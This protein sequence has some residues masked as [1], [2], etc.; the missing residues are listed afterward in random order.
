MIQS[1]I[2]DT[3]LIF[4]HGTY[5]DIST[6]CYIMSLSFI[7]LFAQSLIKSG[8]FNN[9]NLF[10]TCF[11][12][13]IVALIT[14]SELP[15]YKEW[16][17]KL[18][19]KAI[20]YLSQPSEVFS[21]TKTSVVVWVILGTIIQS[22]LFIV[23]YLKLIYE[24]NIPTKRNFIIS[25]L[26]L[27]ITPFI[28]GIGLRGGLQQ[29]P[30]DQSD[31]YFSKNNSANL[32]AVNS[33]WNLGHSIEQNKFYMNHNPYILYPS[34]KAEK[35]VDSLYRIPSDTTIE[36]LT[37][38]KP[39]IVLII[40]ESWS[41][42]LVAA[43]GGEQGITPNFDNLAKSGLLFTNCFASGDRSDQGMAALL[44]AY[45]AQPTTSIIKQPNKFQQLPCILNELKKKRYH[46]SFLFG[47]QL[48]YGNI[49][50]Y[51]YFNGFERI[52]EGKD[53]SGDLPMGKLGVH[54]EYIFNRFLDDMDKE[55]TPFFSTV[56]TL[57]SH[58][59]YDQPIKE[60]LHWGDNERQYINSAYYTDSCLGDFF[61]KAKNKSWYSNTLF[62]LVA[63]HSHNSYRNHNFFTP[64]Y[65]KIPMLFYGDVLKTEFRGYIYN[66]ICSQ[67]DFPAT[68]LS[69]LNL[70][71]SEFRW[72]KNLFNP[73][74]PV[75]AYY[76]FVDGMGWIKPDGYF[77][78]QKE[79]DKI[80]FSNFKDE[81]HQQQLIREGR[82]YL[83]V[84]F[85]EYLNY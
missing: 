19:Y 74:V 14:Y 50:G 13:V 57:S 58:S 41:A 6:T 63:D 36:I 38:K 24:K 5:L 22:L 2:F 51:I 70:N 64:E 1:G 25:A 40:L 29:I 52:I 23:L 67:T 21:S 44:S 82:S 71:H 79:A 49:K 72:S 81:N 77:V 42:D 47:G 11:V 85:Q 78:Y 12:I 7:F 30:I 39:N 62:L 48:S 28:L 54:D 10:Y 84:L 43:L 18:H 53:L 56:F 26:Y 32:A 75:F 17:I 45:P 60:K 31:V 83:Q 33:V 4:W 61:N 3:L 68:L 8:F 34:S 80:I 76:S 15:L 35:T 20:S 59:P 69:Q 9:V 66:K 55:D 16:G 73:N 65:R 37:T 46:S 27:L